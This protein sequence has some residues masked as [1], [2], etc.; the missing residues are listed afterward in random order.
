MS[1]RHEVGQ[2]QAAALF[3]DLEK[4][5]EQIEARHVESSDGLTLLVA[6]DAKLVENARR[7]MATITREQL[8]RG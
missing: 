3:Q 1:Y 6:L 8:G 7:T 2:I 4:L 5:V